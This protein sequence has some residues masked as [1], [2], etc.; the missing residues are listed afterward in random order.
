M[1]MEEQ[2]RKNNLCV[3]LY[4]HIE[5]ERERERGIYA[6]L[7]AKP[8]LGLTTAVEED[9]CIINVCPKSCS[10]A[11]RPDWYFLQGKLYTKQF[12]SILIGYSKFSTNQNA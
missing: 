5:R 4:G 10:T 12:S 8:A 6:A 11:V 1:K 9:F 3:G 2:T 7:E